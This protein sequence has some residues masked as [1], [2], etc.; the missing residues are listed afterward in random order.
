MRLARWTLK[1]RNVTSLEPFMLSLSK[2][3]PGLDPGTKGEGTGR[4][5]LDPRDKPEDDSIHHCH[6]GRSAQARRAGILSEAYDVEQTAKIPDR[7]ALRMASGMTGGVM[8]AP[9]LRGVWGDRWSR[10]CSRG[11]E[12]P[13]ARAAPSSSNGRARR[14]PC[15]ARLCRDAKHGSAMTRGHSG[16]QR[17]ERRRLDMTFVSATSLVLDPRL[18]WAKGP[19]LAGEETGHGTLDPRDKP[20]DDRDG[21]S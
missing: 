2:P 6:P 14:R 10:G 21:A 19:S 16:I 13:F 18:A 12:D 9:C 11:E 4:G 5:T 1:C 3:C 7:H 20:E 17:Q 15:R 8:G